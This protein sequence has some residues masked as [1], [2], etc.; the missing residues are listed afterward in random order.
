MIYT[1]SSRV[2]WAREDVPAG[3]IQDARA[4]TMLTIADIFFGVPCHVPHG[5]YRLLSGP[6]FVPRPQV[7]P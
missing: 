6:L 7:R 2:A 4:L 5:E 3:W 1:G